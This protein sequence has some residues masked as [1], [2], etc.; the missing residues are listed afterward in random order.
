MKTIIFVLIV[1]ALFKFT[2]SSDKPDT[3]AYLEENNFT[4]IMVVGYSYV[5]CRRHGD[6][7]THKTDFVAVNPAGY[8]VRGTVC[9][10][11]EGEIIHETRS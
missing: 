11:T 3:Q 1:F 7:V 9:R 10:T 4:E 8:K 5:G 2:G 6:E